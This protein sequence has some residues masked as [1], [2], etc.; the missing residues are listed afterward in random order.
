MTNRTHLGSNL[1]L[2]LCN[3]NTLQTREE[4]KMAAI[5]KMF[6]Q[7]EKAQNP[8][9]RRGAAQRRSTD[10]SDSTR[11]KSDEHAPRATSHRKTSRSGSK[12]SK[13]PQHKSQHQPSERGVKEEDVRVDDDSKTE[14]LHHG[15]KADSTESPDDLNDD[16]Q[17]PQSVKREDDVEAPLTSIKT[18]LADVKP[19]A[20]PKSESGSIDEDAGD[21]R[22]LRRRDP[23]GRAA[24]HSKADNNKLNK[25]K[26]GKVSD[27][28]TRHECSS[29]HVVSRLGMFQ[30]KKKERLK[31]SFSDE[32][33]ESKPEPVAPI[34]PQQ[35]Q[36][37]V[38]KGAKRF[39]CGSRVTRDVMSVFT[40]T[41]RSIAC[42]RK[43][44]PMANKRKFRAV[45]SSVSATDSADELADGRPRSNSLVSVSRF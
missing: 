32:S 34:K 4:R 7:I 14:S 23:L 33:L 6:E 35:Q 42:R 18:E 22:V 36:Q 15:F 31:P 38:L 20:S 37:Q 29:L 13:H 17:V 16:Q 21:V 44:P 40:P 43:S 45:A 9:K 27:R 8:Q 19:P 10:S 26:R 3:C 12:D 24:K 5:L 28:V 1:T 39:V 2:T 30:T 11:R 25:L 41:D